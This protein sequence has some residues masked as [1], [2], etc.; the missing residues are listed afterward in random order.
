MLDQAEEMEIPLYSYP[1]VDVAET[2]KGTDRAGLEEVVRLVQH[3]QVRFFFVHDINRIARWN[4][5]CIFLLDVFTREF[6]ITIVTDEGVLDLTRLEGLAMTWV[7]SMSGEI[8]NRNKAKHTLKGQI[9]NFTDGS[10]ETWFRKY[11][12]GYKSSEDDLLEKDT[13]EVA[14]AEAI[15][16]IFE[17]AEIHRPYKETIEKVNAQYE[18]VLDEPLTHSRLKTM[19]VD[20]LY[21][22][23]PTV[24]GES[25]GDQ[26]QEATL[27]MPDL[28]IIDEDLF[29]RVNE[30]VEKVRERYSNTNSPGEVLD[31]EFLLFEFGVMPLVESSSEIAV[32]CSKCGSAMVRDGKSPLKNSKR[33]AVRYKCLECD[34]EKKEADEDDERKGSYK[35]FPNTLEFYKIKLFDEI[36]DNIDEVSRFLD[37]KDI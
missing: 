18:N 16:R 32:L 5:F 37:L 8:E 12:I 23:N 22:G 10:Y 34:E 24:S 33:K 26:G 28:Q 3:P 2:G 21:I 31:L 9:E 27:D 11:R 14:I 4:S 17:K 36:V 20:P 19:L 15:F 7:S 29:R 35:T 13:D 6:D 25:I 30:K 1:V